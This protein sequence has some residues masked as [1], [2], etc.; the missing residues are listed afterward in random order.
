MY[1]QMYEHGNNLENGSILSLAYFT[2]SL[3]LGQEYKLHSPAV[4]EYMPQVPAENEQR[5]KWA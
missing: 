4:V 2:K 5:Q 3:C 1:Q